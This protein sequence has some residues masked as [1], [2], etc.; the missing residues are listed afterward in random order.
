M[1]NE[2]RG[3]R[4]EA[5]I[6]A[7]LMNKSDFA[8][9]LNLSSGMVSFYCNGTHA[10]TGRLINSIAELYPELNLDW[11]FHGRGP[12][13]SQDA[14]TTGVDIPSQTLEMEVSAIKKEL[15]RLSLIVD[16]KKKRP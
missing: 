5:F 3:A 7:K 1:T 10:F 12:M 16:K 15:H 8:R 13:I 9:A 6:N 4:L 2:E 11:L 14:P